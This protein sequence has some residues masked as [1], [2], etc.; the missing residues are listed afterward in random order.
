[1]AELDLSL[2]QQWH[3]SNIKGIFENN[4]TVIAIHMKYKK[5]EDYE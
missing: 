4:S 5:R 1:M 2:E 3:V